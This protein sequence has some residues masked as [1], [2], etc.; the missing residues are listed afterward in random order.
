MTRFRKAL[1][2]GVLM[3]CMTLLAACSG[4]AVT[5]GEDDG[6][7]PIK[8]GVVGPQSGP[9]A[10]FGKEFPIGAQ[11]AVDWIEENGGVEG[12]EIELHTIDDQADPET[13]VAG[14]RELT[15]EGVH[16]FIG[17]VNSP[18][19][20]ALGPVMEQTN[21]V[22]LTTAA[23]AQEITHENFSEHVFRIT[24]N[25]YMRQR[26]QAKLAAEVA[27]DATKWSLVGPDHAYG[28]S[29]LQAFMS[30][31]TEFFPDADVADPVLAPFGASDYRNSMSRVMGQNPQGVFSSL[32]ASDA[33][34][35]YKQAAA[36]GLWD[37]TVLMDASNEFYV[38]RAMK[39]NTPDHWSAFH[40]YVG[41][42]DNEM[43]NFISERYTAEHGTEPTGFVG[44][45]FA[46]VM[47][48]A[49]AVEAGGSA[50]TEDLIENLEGLKWETPSG[51]RT[52][53]AEDHQTIKDV[54]FVRLRGC[55]D[56]KGGYEVVDAQVI[57]G[58]DL[59]EPAAPGEPT[60]YGPGAGL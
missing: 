34:T 60:E 1:P 3:V 19:A 2:L 51:E 52:I 5:G 42:Y 39:A 8:I 6:D 26:A 28:V 40:W 44:E 46:A 37:D 54:N 45:S 36:M 50:A 29:T 56:C 47:A 33:V 22:L 43:T 38:A 23:H 59:I 55:A 7:G 20:L 12:R 10:L 41:A 16:I 30:G 4:S 35:A 32:Y 27:P 11:L 13:A 58:A 24:D 17:T 15:D 53:R 57:P 25:P 9:S 21:S 48:V 49:E 31:L 14:V 18:V